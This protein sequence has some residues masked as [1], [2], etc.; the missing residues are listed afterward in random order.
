[1]VDKIISFFL[2]I[3]S[4]VIPASSSKIEQL[5]S[6]TPIPEVTEITTPDV[7][8]VSFENQ[9]Y[10]I[11]YS[12]INGKKISLIPNFKSKKVTSSIYS[13][14]KCK[15]AIN[16]GFY[17]TDEK[18]LGLYI[19]NGKSYQENIVN[20]NLLTG[21]FYLDSNN[22]PKISNEYNSESKNIFQSGPYYLNSNKIK[23]IEDKESRRS[24]IVEDEHANIYA[25]SVLLKD[26]QY[27]GPLLSDLG[28]IIFSVTY[29]FKAVK[30]LNLDGGSASSY[31]DAYNFHVSE[32]TPVGSVICVT[33]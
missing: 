9:N 4:S 27:G 21:Y 8:E 11:Y 15:I 13:E 22:Q 5:I 20:N 31:L 17:T 1:M 7:I 28:S 14:N 25:V 24:V 18:P 6:P 2:A 29:P 33:L 32:L 12:Q 10:L 3:L 30:A 19:S 16:G 26:N 23:M